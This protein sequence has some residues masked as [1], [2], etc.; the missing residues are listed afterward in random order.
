MVI[1]MKKPRRIMKLTIECER[2]SIFRNFRAPQSGWCARCEAETQMKSVADSAR[3]IG[4]SELAIYQLL[5]DG[6]LHF[7]ED[8]EGRVLICLYSLLKKK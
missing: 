6:G 3:E 4:L 1:Q 5:G 2:I 8:T 7:T